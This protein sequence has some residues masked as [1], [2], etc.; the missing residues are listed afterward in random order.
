M[1]ACGSTLSTFGLLQLLRTHT[2]THTH[3]HRD[4]IQVLLKSPPLSISHLPSSPFPSVADEAQRTLTLY[5][6]VTLSVDEEDKAGERCTPLLQSP[7]LSIPLSAPYTGSSTPQ[8]LLFSPPPLLAPRRQRSN[9]TSSR[10]SHGRFPPSSRFNSLSPFLYHTLSPSFS[11][12]PPLTPP[13]LTLLVS[14]ALS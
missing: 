10:E 5:S 1:C 8:I 13:P 7:P 9:C 4:T 2:H 14:S 6:H 11:T 12:A 3:T